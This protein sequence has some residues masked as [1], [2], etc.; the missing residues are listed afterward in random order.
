MVL[1]NVI[2]IAQWNSRS[3]KARIPEIIYHSSNFDIFIISET[4]LNMTDNI[5]IIGF[6]VV[7]QDRVGRSGGGVL[8]L[9]R[10]S[11]RYQVLKVMN[12]CQD[13]LEI[14]T[15]LRRCDIFQ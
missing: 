9:V 11:L 14:S 13:R 2:R 4:W 3:F 7:R 12:N 8:I 6:D 5:Y 10:S 1:N 15:C